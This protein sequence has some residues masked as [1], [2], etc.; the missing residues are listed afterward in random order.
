MS[1]ET[2]KIAAKRREVKGNEGKE[3]YTHLNAELQRM[4]KRDKKA[5]LNN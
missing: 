1:K 5:F 2:L 3:G 4:A